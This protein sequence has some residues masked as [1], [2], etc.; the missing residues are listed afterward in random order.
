MRLK[1]LFKGFVLLGFLAFI[2]AA[3]ALVVFGFESSPRITAVEKLSVQDM[4]RAK[5]LIKMHDPRKLKEREVKRLNITERDLDI[6]IRYGLSRLPKAGNIRSRVHIGPNVA[7]IFFTFMFPAKPMG[8]YLNLSTTLSENTSEHIVQKMTIGRITL[9]GWMLQPVRSFFMILAKK[10][11]V[12]PEMLLAA[13]AVKEIRFLNQELLLVY[14]W[15]SEVAE[16][17][18]E[19]GR[20]ILI[21][22]EDRERLLAY[23]EKLTRNTGAIKDKEASL[24]HLLG[25]LFDYSM[26]RSKSTGDP[27]AENRA[28][29]IALTLYVNQK[30][31]SMLIGTKQGERIDQPKRKINVTLRGRH[32]LA[33]HFTVSA[34]IAAMADSELSNV[35]GI[36]KEIDDSR[37]G[38]GFSFVDLLADR[39]GVRFAE[40][41]TG[42]P[43]QAAHVQRLMGK[44]M[45]ESFLMPEIDG[46][47]EGMTEK[48]FKSRYQDLDSAAFQNIKTEIERRIGACGLYR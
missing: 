28:A 32:D 13:E 35:L 33:Q 47:P 18:K 27:V 10:T 31:V 15:R 37:G 36:F 43:K 38:S 30:P 3:V 2:G 39:A 23:N 20:K 26:E 4:E 12:F 9:K 24:V 44:A 7:E 19:K 5:T 40:M 34:A 22:E 45:S 11:D 17:I 41:S 16:K 21:P 29:I 6:M 46:L 42:S 1:S 48:T 14:E 25:Q 8:S